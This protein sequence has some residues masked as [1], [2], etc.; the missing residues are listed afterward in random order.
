MT[1]SNEPSHLSDVRPSV[2]VDEYQAGL[3]H[4]WV[5]PAVPLT[6]TMLKDCFHGVAFKPGVGKAWAEELRKIADSIDSNV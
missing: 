5:S 2:M 3:V 4:V 1:K 6:P